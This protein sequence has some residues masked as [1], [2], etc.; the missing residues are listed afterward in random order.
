[1]KAQRD[2][3]AATQLFL[4]NEPLTT[5]TIQK[6]FPHLL[7]DDDAMS[8][9]RLGLWKAALTFNT[10]LGFKFS[11]YAVQAIRNQLRNELKTQA[12]HDIPVIS[13]D[14]P[15]NDDRDLFLIDILPDR[16]NSFANVDARRLVEKT[17][18]LRRLYE[19]YTIKDIAEL[20]CRSYGSV[21]TQVHRERIKARVIF[22]EASH[23]P[24]PFPT[25]RPSTGGAADRAALRP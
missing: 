16:N 23:P 13:L 6:Y 11:T 2:T 20:T 14:V 17:E 19:G 18:V 5:F 1:M 21:E 9:A 8:I 15:V 10:A 22:Q 7:F 4:E 12:R 25:T 3:E 24:S